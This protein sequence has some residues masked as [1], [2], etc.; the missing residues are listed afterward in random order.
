MLAA[1]R[2]ICLANT[3]QRAAYANLMETVLLSR[4]RLELYEQH[5]LH[6]SSSSSVGHTSVANC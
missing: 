4:P 6:L 5:G 2:L 1:M 3:L